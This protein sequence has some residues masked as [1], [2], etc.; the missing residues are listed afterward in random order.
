MIERHITFTV[1]AG[2]A[3]EF[4]RFIAEQYGRAM[5]QAPGFV[6]IEL[7]READSLTRYQMCFRFQDAASAAGWRTSVE[8]TG[9]QPALNA[10]VST[11][12]VQGYEVI[13]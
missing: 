4:E 10:L 6:R 3:A 1:D 13:G 12:E 2:R 8:H 5:A 11:P 9:L 7:L